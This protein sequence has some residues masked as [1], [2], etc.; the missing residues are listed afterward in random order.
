VEV[1][2]KVRLLAHDGVDLI[3]ML[4]TARSDPWQQPYAIEF[5]EEELQAGVDE[6]SHF[7]LRVACMPTPRRESERDSRRRSFGGARELLDDDLIAMAKQH[8]TYL[9]MDIYDEECSRPE[10]QPDRRPPT[11]SSTMRI[12]DESSARISAKPCARE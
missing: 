3:K 11:S 4:S 7:G 10:P 1:R 12:W 8:G 2:Q 9:D 6:A 5:T